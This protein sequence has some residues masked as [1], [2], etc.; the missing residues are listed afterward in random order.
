MFVTKELLIQ[1]N[2]CKDGLAWFDKFCPNGAELSDLITHRFVPMPFLH[3]GYNHLYPSQE[4]TELYLK[5]IKVENSEG[6]YLSHKIKNSKYVSNS[7]EVEDSN[8]VMRSTDIKNST[9][10]STSSTVDSSHQIFASNFIYNSGKV[11]D[12]N[13]VTNCENIVESTYII[14]SHNVYRSSIISDSNCIKNSSKLE[15]CYF[16]NDCTNLK[17]CFACQGIQDGEYLVFNQKIEPAQFEVIKKQFLSMIE[18]PLKFT[19]YWPVDIIGPENP[20][21]DRNQVRHYETIPPKVWKWV[22]TLPNYS[23]SHLYYM[24]L[25]PEFLTK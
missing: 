18:I 11:Y 20:I 9:D 4:E 15:D 7:S 2:A 17:H 16:C 6:T 25:L 10:V 13:N 19:M 3:W 5:T 24:T 14:N 21:I 22:Q 12:S 1:K 23:S 8:N